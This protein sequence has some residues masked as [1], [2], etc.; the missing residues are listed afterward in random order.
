MRI[1]DWII[2]SAVVGAL[3]IA[4]W[5]IG[6]LRSSGSVLLDVVAD[7][8]RISE[9]RERL[10][11][12]TDRLADLHV[13]RVGPGHMAVIASIVSDQPELPDRYKARLENL[14]GLSHV[15]IEVNRRPLEFGA[16]VMLK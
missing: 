13:W 3:V 9:I 8:Q 5:S 7:P 10:E 16:S 15:T 2:Y 4:R 1:P 6:L 14:A 12:G 11:V